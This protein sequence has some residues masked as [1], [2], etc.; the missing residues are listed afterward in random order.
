MAGGVLLVTKTADGWFVNGS[1]NGRDIAVS[2]DA[3]RLYTASGAPYSCTSVD[4][5][6]LA[7]VGSLPGGDAYPN[8]VEVTRDGRVICGISGVYSSADFWVHSPAG[9]LLGSYKIGGSAGTLK[10]SNMVVTPDGLVVV[11]LTDGAVLAFVP[12]GP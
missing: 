4:P 5:A 10:A 3:G 8:N 2:G 12:I 11:A 9:A 6:S 7:Y 1:S